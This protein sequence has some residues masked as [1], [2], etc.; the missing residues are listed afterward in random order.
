MRT[1]TLRSISSSLQ[2]SALL[3]SLLLS[4]SCDDASATSPAPAVGGR[5]VAVAASGKQAS[6]SDLCDVLKPG[7]DAPTF[8][9]PPLDGA[10]PPQGSSYR[11]VNVWATW[12]P[13]CIE[14]LPLITRWRDELNQA[15]T[16]IELLLMS[17][18]ADAAVIAPFQAKHPEVGGTLHVSDTKQLEGWLTSIGLD[19]GAPLPIHVIV[20]PQGKVRCARTGALRESDFPLLKKLLSGS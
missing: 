7:P 5:V 8:S 19:S 20:D 12:C 4:T 17:V 1:M 2:A 10:A 3:L 11:W 9:F 16:R 14:E 18:D 15:G 6:E 13:P